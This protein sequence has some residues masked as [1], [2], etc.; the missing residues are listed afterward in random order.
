MSREPVP[1]SPA[2]RTRR[3]RTSGRSARS[4][5]SFLRDL[6]VIV[7]V[8]VLASFLI[9][10]FLVR[11]FYIPSASMENTLLVNDRVLVNEL[12][13]HLIPLH[14]G[15]VIVFKD[16][17]G[18]LDN[19]PAV[20]LTPLGS[21]GDWVLSFVGLSTRDQD[22][23]LIKRVIGLPGDHIECCNALGQ[24]SVNGT[25]L[26][27]QPYVRL[28]PGTTAVSDVA[29]HETVPKNRLWVMGDNRYQSSDSRAHVN[30]PSLGFVPIENVV[31]RA[32]IVSWPVGR[33]GVLSAQPDT[34]GGVPAPTP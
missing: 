30:G 27:E 26:D 14:R 20:P 5:R 1:P 18:W 24:M 2:T 33:W 7:L 21:V 19:P 10:T 17:G 32:F 11:S 29:I 31:G 9:K 28:P 34:F 16:P 23:H 4:S 3:R 13:P 6:L 22:D 25:P 15:D 8:A 12:V